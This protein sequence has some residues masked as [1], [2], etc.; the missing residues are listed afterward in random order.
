MFRFTPFVHFFPFRK[1]RFDTKSSNAN[2]GSILKHIFRF[3]LSRLLRRDF[4]IH[5]HLMPFI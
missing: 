4:T 3:S 1:G 2:G 5:H